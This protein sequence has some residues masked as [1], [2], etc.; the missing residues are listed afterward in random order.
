MFDLLED[1]RA[2]QDLNPA[3]VLL[4][5]VKE[6]AKAFRVQK[7]CKAPLIPRLSFSFEFPF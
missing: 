4:G 1:S 7:N 6:E 2:V 3:L 5:Q